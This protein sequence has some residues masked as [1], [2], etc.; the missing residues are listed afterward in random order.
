MYYNTTVL[1]RLLKYLFSEGTCCIQCFIGLSSRSRGL[2]VRTVHSFLLII[3]RVIFNFGLSNI[4]STEPAQSFYKCYFNMNRVLETLLVSYSSNISSTSQNL[5]SAN[6]DAVECIYYC[7]ARPSLCHS[8][9]NV[10]QNVMSTGFV[11][12]TGLHISFFKKNPYSKQFQHFLYSQ[13]A[14]I[15]V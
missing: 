3:A 14:D 5:N 7:G 1:P 15:V 11:F 10:I 12:L 8:S 2:E 4:S 6:L 9:L 13:S